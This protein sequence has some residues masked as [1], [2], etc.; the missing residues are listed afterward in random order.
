MGGGGQKQ[1]GGVHCFQTLNGGGDFV[2][3]PHWLYHLILVGAGQFGK[4]AICFWNHGKEWLFFKLQQLNSI[5]NILITSFHL[6]LI[7]IRKQINQQT[8]NQLKSKWT[9]MFIAIILAIKVTYILNNKKHKFAE[10]CLR[11]NIVKTI[12]NWGGSEFLTCRG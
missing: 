12:N 9:V 8:M 7:I 3:M 5:S 2:F 4:G 11:R 10:K 1:L 6:I